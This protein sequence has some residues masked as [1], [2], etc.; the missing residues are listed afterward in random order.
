MICVHEIGDL[1]SS[2]LYDF[3]TDLEGWTVLDECATSLRA[4]ETA[5][6]LEGDDWAARDNTG[7]HGLRLV[8]SSDY[9]QDWTKGIIESPSFKICD[10]TSIS[11]L[12]SGGSY[13]GDID[14]ENVDC[15]AGYVMVQ[16]EYLDS[17][18]KWK[19]AG[20]VHGNGNTQLTEKDITPPP[21]AYGK[22]G[23][24]RG[25]DVRGEVWAQV[26]FDYVMITGSC[27]ASGTVALPS[28]LSLFSHVASQCSLNMSASAA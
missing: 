16:L 2:V 20:Y 14:P 3:E 26:T 18:G 6:Q 5:P 22:E 27:G 12:V 13:G 1:P 10:D 23:R 17:D 24:L 4:Y 28:T 7:G 8:R 11:L 25:Y 9:G 21:E 15:N 19:A